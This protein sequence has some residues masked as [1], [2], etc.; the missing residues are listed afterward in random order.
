MPPV[1]K[2]FFFLIVY[3]LFPFYAPG[4]TWM[5][6]AAPPAEQLKV[7]VIEEYPHATDAFTQG[8]L[9][10]EEKLY[11]S[12]G[13]RGRSTLRRVQLTSGTVEQ[14]ISL[15]DDYFGEGLARVEERLIQLT[16]TS[17]VAPVYDIETFEQIGE[18]SYTGQGWGVDYDGQMLIMSNGSE[19]LTFRDPETF[20]ALGQVRVT[21]NGREQKNLNELE[22][23][24]GFVYANVWKTDNIVKIT[25]NTGRVV[26][27]IDASGLLT[28]EEDARADVLNGIAYDPATETFLITGKLWPK[29]FRVRF[30]P[31]GESER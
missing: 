1:P 2:L 3:T 19:F 25:P 13:I 8:L 22:Y 16:W 29:L 14:M 27:V 17:G 24:D 15:P 20:E 9:L 23:V 10:H 30:V 5:L 21:L 12:T 11:E 7:E 18:F 31:A 28:P 6:Q 4:T 26:A